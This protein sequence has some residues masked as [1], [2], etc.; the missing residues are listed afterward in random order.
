MKRLILIGLGVF[1]LERVPASAWTSLCPPGTGPVWNGTTGQGE[2]QPGGL[3]DVMS[4]L[5]TV[6]PGMIPTPIPT[7]WTTPQPTFAYTAPTPQPTKA[8]NPSGSASI[9][10]P[11][12]ASNACADMTPTI[13]VT[14][15]VDGDPIALGVPAIAYCA[16]A[17]VSY[18][19][20]VT[21]AGV[22]TVRYCKVGTTTCNPN[23]GTFT[24]RIVRP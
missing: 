4:I 20:R 2:C 8:L 12:T 24:A 1:V 13:A 16:G 23:A 14:G 10:V 5:P 7:A 9:D 11:A 15:A 6:L 3:G 22:V 21:A 18:E 19:A 17:G